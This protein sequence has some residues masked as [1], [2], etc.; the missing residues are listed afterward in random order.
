MGGGAVIGARINCAD[1]RFPLRRKAAALATGAAFLLAA[2]G[3]AVDHPLPAPQQLGSGDAALEVAYPAGNARSFV[4]GEHNVW[5]IHMSQTLQPR[6]PHATGSVESSMD[7]E[8][9]ETVALQRDGTA[10]LTLEVTGAE[11]F[12]FQAALEQDAALGRGIT[13]TSG[14][15]RLAISGDEESM[16][17]FGTPDEMRMADVALK[18]HLLNP[19]LPA[20]SYEA[21]DAFTAEAVLPTGW[22]RYAHRLERATTAGDARRRQGVE[23]VSMVSTAG[24]ETEINLPSLD[25]PVETIE[26]GEAQLNE[27]FLATMFQVLVPPGTDPASLLPDFPIQVGDAH[28][29]DHAH[30]KR[31]PKPRRRTC[32]QAV[33]ACLA[34]VA[35][36]ACASHPQYANAMTSVR[37][38]GPIEFQQ[39]STLH[40]SSGLLVHSV[41]RASAQLSGTTIRPD[42]AALEDLGEQLAALTGL[43]VQLDGSWTIEQ[44]LISELPQE[45]AAAA[46]TFST[47]VV[48]V[49]LAVVAALGIGLLVRRSK[50]DSSSSP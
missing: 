31:R 39:E 41:T 33:L 26:G 8:L 14:P 19:A 23:V 42:D 50:A 28:V 44:T 43:D 10:E 21:G 46:D 22:S 9:T 5:S 37:L 36:S 16:D 4:D 18:A 48:A 30:R 34:L 7:L 3:A 47:P 12:G 32:R 13:L 29:H 24:A 20:Q 49:G 11:A 38:G 45:P 35:L 40:R 2:T 25:N 17:F 27:F 6:G 1:S 15:D